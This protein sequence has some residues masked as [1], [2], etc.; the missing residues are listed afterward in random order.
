MDTAPSKQVV[1]SVLLAC[2][3]LQIGQGF[4][5]L[6]SATFG[7][8]IS[9][10]DW[11]RAQFSL[12]ASPLLITMALASPLIGRLLESL[13]C[14]LVACSAVLL[15][16]LCF[17][18]FSLMQN[19]TTF[20][21]INIVFGIA[22]AGVS[23]LV[24]GSVATSW[25]RE[26]QGT[27]LALVFIGSNVGGATIPWLIHFL[28]ELYDWRT[29]L[30]I[31]AVAAT[32]LILPPV[33]LF[34]KQPVANHETE[35]EDINITN[36][37]TPIDN[38]NFTLSEALQTRSFWLLAFLLF[39]FFFYLLAFNQHFII[40][41]S[42]SGFENARAAASFSYA[43]AIGIIGKL[44]IG[45]LTDK[46]SVKKTALLNFGVLAL[47]CFALLIITQPGVLPVFLVLHGFTTAAENVLLPLLVVYCFGARH[48]ASIY[49]VLMLTLLP[50]GTLGPIFASYIHD[51]LQDYT[52][53]LLTFACLNTLA[54]IG[55]FFIRKESLHEQSRK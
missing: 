22:M 33:L 25:A 10:L 1:F 11:S 23:D 47:A 14:R 29:A 32:V 50:G 8:I 43:V 28:S 2:F 38:H 45:W 39:S 42:D 24:A 41:L 17:F 44:S 36:S 27:T 46:S 16:S 6:Y 35:S 21:L 20:F 3:V 12:G 18:A 30:Q 48:F 5:Y 15:I 51:S 19:L 54:F 37:I 4:G 49:G 53:A 26:K 55:V 40:Y 31:L 52:W 13:G 34:L 9:E 7:P